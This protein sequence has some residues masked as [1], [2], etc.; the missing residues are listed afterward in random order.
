MSRRQTLQALAAAAIA[1]AVPHNKAFA[2]EDVQV[3]I[4]Y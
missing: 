2:A 4:C 3:N 1:V